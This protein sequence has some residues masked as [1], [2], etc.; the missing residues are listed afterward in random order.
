MGLLGANVRWAAP[1]S[2]LSRLFA[3]NELPSTCRFGFFGIDE[4]AVHGGLGRK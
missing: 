2:V 4:N 3:N 1:A